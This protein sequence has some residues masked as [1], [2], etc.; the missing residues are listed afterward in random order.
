VLV[1]FDAA[2]SIHQTGTGEYILD[3]VV[4][5][6]QSTNSGSISGRVLPDSVSTTVFAIQA[7][8]TIT[9]TITAS[10]GRY[11]LSALSAG[12]YALGFHPEG[13]YRDTTLTGVTV[14]SGHVTA[15]ADVELTSQ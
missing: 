5:A 15:V 13:A 1:D 9:S 12:T 6:V 2:Q 7:A 11:T 4:R 3:P 10:D 8:D 14:T